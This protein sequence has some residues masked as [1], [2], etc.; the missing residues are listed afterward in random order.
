[1]LIDK[2]LGGKIQS[3]MEGVDFAAIGNQFTEFL[4]RMQQS[5]INVENGL[6]QINE[7]LTLLEIRLAHL[8]DDVAEAI[9]DSTGVEAWAAPVNT[10]LPM[11]D[12]LPPFSEQDKPNG[13]HYSE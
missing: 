2:L 13:Q 11:L 10:E 4:K 5:A 9:R 1:M 6:A 12:H 3:M 8:P 7:R